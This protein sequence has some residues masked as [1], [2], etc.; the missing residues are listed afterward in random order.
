[1]RT[2]YSVQRL[3]LWTTKQLFALTPK[4]RKWTDSMKDI[5]ESEEGSHASSGDAQHTLL[6]VN[7]V[8]RAANIQ[9]P[10]ELQSHTQI[11][12]LLPHSAEENRSF[13]HGYQI[14]TNI[15]CCRAEW[16]A[17]RSA[18]EDIHPNHWPRY[19]SRA[20][21]YFI[22]S[23]G[24][25]TYSNLLARESERIDASSSLSK[26]KPDNVQL[27]CSS[28]PNIGSWK[29]ILPAGKQTAS[30]YRPTASL[31]IKHRDVNIGDL[32]TSTGRSRNTLYQCSLWLN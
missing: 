13:T 14:P 29:S 30:C 7:R 18:Q 28:Q 21:G 27:I 17:L 16:W 31:E 8:R 5:R 25:I 1:M 3:V 10:S 20:F 19:R 2:V 12:H 6:N 11:N 26:Q 9:K 32:Q 15:R 24:W 22:R 4:E 23:W